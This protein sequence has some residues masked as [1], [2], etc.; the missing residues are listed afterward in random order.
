MT[1]TDKEQNHSKDILDFVCEN[2]VHD[3][4]QI[5]PLTFEN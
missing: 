2:A 5:C 3:Y 1:L 4:L